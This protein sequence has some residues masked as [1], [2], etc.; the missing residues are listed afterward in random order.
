MKHKIVGIIIAVIFAL[1]VAGSILVLT[2]PKKD[3]VRILLHGEMLRAVDLSTAQDTTFDIRTDS[4]VNTVEIRDHRIRVKDADCPDQTCVSMGWLSSSAMP[5][6][7]LPH[8]LVIEFV[9][10]AGDV[11]AITR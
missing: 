9:E 5:I 8:G 3:A 11:D 7:C 6:V 4:G 10:D 1:G 2:A